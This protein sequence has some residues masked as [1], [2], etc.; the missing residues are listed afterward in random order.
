MPE[1][2]SGTV[3]LLFSDIEGSTALVRELG[4]AWG[5]V[6]QRQRELCRQAWG[7]HE[8]HELG[9]E[10]DSFM[11]VFATAGAGV[12]AAADAQRL[13][14]AESWPQAIRVE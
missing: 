9:T 5:A 1:L 12:A 10:G 8:G 3:T 2:P 13:I 6:L 4:E 7:A 11:V 14:A